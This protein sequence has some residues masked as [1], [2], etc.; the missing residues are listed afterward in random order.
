MGRGG[1][2]G[3]PWPVSRR[4]T[5][6]PARTAAPGEVL[7]QACPDPGCGLSVVATDHDAAIPLSDRSGARETL[8]RG[9]RNPTRTARPS[10][11]GGGPQRAGHTELATGRSAGPGAFGP[12]G[13]RESLDQRHRTDRGASGFTPAQAARAD[14]S[15]DSGTR[16]DG[17]EGVW[18]SGSR[19][20]VCPGPRPLRS[21]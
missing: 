17:D 12:R 20:Y 9:P 2:A 10:L 21:G 1:A 3:R 15:D 8:P 14:L 5:A 4:G 18:S 11:Y 7:F 13:S 6:P 16:L 19:G